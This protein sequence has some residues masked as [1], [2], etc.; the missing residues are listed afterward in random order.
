M[1]RPEAREVIYDEARWELLRSLRA[2]A[3]RIMEALEAKGISSIVHGSLARGDVR[4]TSDVDIFIPEPPVSAIVEAALELSGFRPVRRLLV[5]ATPAYVPKAY[6]ELD[7]RTSV[8]FP[9]ARM[10]PVE[11]EFYTF[12]GELGLD[13][14]RAGKRVPGVDKRLMLIEPTE[15]GHVE[16]SIIGR[17]GEVARLL[18]ISVEAV[19]DRVKA[20]LR[21]DE[22]GR[23]GVLL[24][25]ELGPDESFEAVLADIA[26]ENPAVRR[27]LARR[28]GARI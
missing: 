13:G 11:R 25:R 23:T 4:P 19:L 3:M 5:Q 10:R 6:I 21:R 7:E 16:S 20:L 28:P 1:R 12:G 26:A 27:R 17:E 2:R 18:G 14:L 15:L 8:S 9:L 22:V 24:K